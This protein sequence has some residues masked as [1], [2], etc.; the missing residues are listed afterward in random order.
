MNLVSL[1]LPPLFCKT[2]I[3]GGW[4]ELKFVTSLH[5]VEFGELVKSC[6]ELVLLLFPLWSLEGEISQQYFHMTSHINPSK[7]EFLEW[8]RC[9]QAWKAN[10][11][12][13]SLAMSHGARCLKS[14]LR[15]TSNLWKFVVLLCMLY[16][17][18]QTAY[19][20]GVL[21]SRAVSQA[22]FT[23]TKLTWKNQKKNTPN[24]S[25]EIICSVKA[26]HFKF[27]H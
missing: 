14:I 8:H 17:S 19:E 18:A 4:T 13:G 23:R 16:P 25:K 26:D 15:C 1:T 10:I 21:V 5:K 11:C 9:F 12:L 6:S 20:H 2:G 24:F 7:W 27:R 22:A 3:T